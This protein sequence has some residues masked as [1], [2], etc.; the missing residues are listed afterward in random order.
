MDL[1]GYGGEFWGS[2]NVI[3][4]FYRRYREILGLGSEA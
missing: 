1:G 2:I 3:Q 4:G